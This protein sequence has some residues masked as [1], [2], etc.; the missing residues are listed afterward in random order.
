[1]SG[2][3]SLDLSVVVP[4]YNEAENIAELLERLE[5]TIES[6][7]R[8]YELIL[9]NDG[10]RDRSLELLRAEA[11][12]R[13]KLVVID[14]NRNYGQHAAVF[15]GLE[16]SRGEVVVTLDADLQNPPEEIPKLLAKVDEGFDVVG[17]VRADRED[18]AFRRAASRLVNRLSARAAGVRLSDIGSMLRA[19]RRPVVR[20]LCDSRELSTFIPVLAELYAGPVAEVTVAHAARKHGESK[21]SL[22]ALIRLQFDL[23]TSFSV[24][25]L[26]LTMAIG[27]ATS[28]FSMLIA[29]V[30]IA[31]RLI[32]GREWAVGGVFTLFALLFSLLGFLL[33]AIGLLGEYVGRI[34]LEVRHRP[35][36]LVRE[37]IRAGEVQPR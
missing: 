26:R 20:A 23:V 16:A 4:V 37:T 33:F 2:A 17:S 10:S 34:Y 36:F 11:L 9:V 1:V 21:Y 3:P 22:L 31:G 19:Y 14:L 13:P 25:P 12:R 28:I 35:R 24:L 5:G 27:L 8:S 15:A 30:L 6:T 32:F 29:F 7:G 18:S